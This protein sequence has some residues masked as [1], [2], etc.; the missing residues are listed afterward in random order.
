MGL[1]H[2]YGEAVLPKMIGCACADPKIA[3]LREKIVPLAEGRVFEIG[4]GGGLNHPFYDTA[5]VTSFAGIDP[6]GALLEKARQSARAKGWQADI[7]E[8]KGEAIP[9]ANGSFDTVVCTYTLCSVDD[10]A[11]VLSELRRILR[12]GGRILFLEHGRSPDPGPARWQRRIEPVWKRL[13]GNCHLTRPVSETIGQAGFMLHRT[14]HKYMEKM[15][16]W[17]GWMEWGIGQRS[18]EGSVRG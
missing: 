7:R 4:C 1:R 14:E 18:V 15:P 13:M 16:K 2:W 5:K 8:G 6:N 11:Q 12:P 3:A 17:A 9:F 10:E